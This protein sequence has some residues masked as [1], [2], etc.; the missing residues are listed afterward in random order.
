MYIFS[1]SFSMSNPLRFKPQKRVF[2]AVNRSVNPTKLHAVEI[3]RA[4]WQTHC[5]SVEILQDLFRG[6]SQALCGCAFVYPVQGGTATTCE[7]KKVQKGKT[8]NGK[9]FLQIPLNSTLSHSSLCPRLCTARHDPYMPI[10]CSRLRIGTKVVTL[11]RHVMRDSDHSTGNKSIL[12]LGV[13]LLES[14]CSPTPTRFLVRYAFCGCSLFWNSLHAS[15][16]CFFGNT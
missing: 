16:A 9:K 4:L 5:L 13:Q 1:V 2:T 6:L 10:A 7:T 11:P 14:L 3:Q 15:I 12:P 8:G